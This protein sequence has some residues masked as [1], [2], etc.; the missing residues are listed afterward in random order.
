MASN[1]ALFQPMKVGNAQLEHRVVLAPLTRFR[2]DANHVPT[3]LQE[4]YYAQRATKGGLLISEATF[5]SPTAGAY[6]GAPGIYTEEQI[7]AWKR[8]TDAVHAKGGIIYVQLW[9]VGR[10]TSSVL[11][12]NNAQPVSASEVAIQGPCLFTPGKDF[13]VPHALTVEE[14]AGITQDYA[15][16]AKNAVAAGFDGVE[17]HGANGYL[18]DQFTNTSSNKRTDQYGGSIE[19]RTRFTLEVV[20]TISDAIGA[21]RVGI[22]LSPWSEFQDMADETPYDTWSHIVRELKAHHANMAYLHMIEPR[23]DFSRKTEND[24]VNTLDPF[25]ELWKDGVFMSAGGYTTKP[26]L[27][28]EV[29][30]KTGNLIAIGRAFIANPD[31]VYRL[32]NG[33]PL[34]RYNRDTFYTQGAVGYTDYPFAE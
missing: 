12:P 28:T 29:A 1:S 3:A 4:E 13:E 9:H 10:A 23:D 33:V 21:E 14:I 2:S 11:L 34:T 32:K 24:T 7:V 30:D 20:K 19:N 31:I 6:P 25:R 17:I 8:V 16:A 26:E 15:Q 5:I 22:R 18:L 27:A